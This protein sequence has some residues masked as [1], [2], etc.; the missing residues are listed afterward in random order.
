MK[1][2]LMISILGILCY[3]GVAYYNYMN[4]GV[5]DVDPNLETLVEDWKSEMA[6]NG[7]SYEDKYNRIRRI[8]IVSNYRV[9]GQCDHTN[10]IIR[11]D[12]EQL[13][14]GRYT[15]MVVLWH[16]LGHCVFKCY[17]VEGISIMNSHTKTESYYKEHWEEMK[18]SYIKNIRNGI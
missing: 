11:I 10:R 12:K 3:Y 16:E 5:V 13:L 9:A 2:L 18:A 7:I 14:K 6:E 8:E 17:H 1:K 4:V 15:A